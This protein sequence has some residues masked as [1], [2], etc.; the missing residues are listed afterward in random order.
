MTFPLMPHHDGSPLYVSDSSPDFGGVVQVRL[1]V[2]IDFGELEMV[3]VRSTADHEP[4]FVEAEQLG[5]T[6]GWQWWEAS[7]PVRNRRV[8]Y[9][10]MLCHAD[11]RTEWLS[12]A[13]VSELETRDSEDFALVVGNPQPSW[14]PGAV[15]YQIFPDRFARSAA[16]DD[17][18]VPP[19]AVPAAWDDPVEPVSPA[20]A[21]QFYGG[22]L[23]GI[24]EHL[25]HLVDLGVTLMYLTPVFPAA[26][27]HRY[28]ATTFDEVDPVL[29]GNDAYARLIEA[30]HDRGIR[31]IG[32]L[33]SNHSGSEHDWFRA[34]FGHPGAPEEEFYY[35]T[36]D[37]NTSYESWLGFESLPKLDWSSE[38]LARR[39]VDGPESV[40]ARWLEPP[41]SLDGW[42]IDVANMTGRSGAADHNAAVRQAIRRTMTAVDPDTYLVAES[43]ADATG[44]L[45]GDAWQG[46]MTYV[47]FTRP[48]WNWLGDL[49]TAPY[50][51]SEGE[52][53]TT[54][55]YFGQPV[56]Q[57][58]RYTAR[59]FVDSL[60][61]FTSG[62][63]W[64]VRLGMMNT[65][66]S[67]DTARFATHARPE[68]IPVAVGL[69]MTL[70]GVP[71]VWAGDEFGEEGVDGEMSRTPMPWH[72]V[73]EPARADRLAI[74]RRL[75]AL[76]HAHPV[77]STGGL[78]WVH[79][80]DETLLFV[81]ESDQET[82]LVLAARGD[83]SVQL[84]AGRV[85]GADE[86]V[87]V[88]GDAELSVQAAG[89]VVI[90]A[91]GPA[92]A[93]W[94]LPGVTRPGR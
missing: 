54:P 40:V 8:G 80:D 34:A 69:S 6:T 88:H 4:F 16:A 66:D 61:R 75:I 19:W 44:D 82:L 77:L 21:R 36:D 76:R 14:L 79:V 83:L 63:P 22:D 2:P 52:T 32:D 85:V 7:L 81:R 70:P 23:D 73:D 78:R 92:F 67:H 41:F 71:V 28:D 64:S 89:A 51:D 68:V 72:G 24:R 65:L 35:F 58:P 5:V 49:S 20:R 29:G 42:R 60:D 33:T 56:R 50:V 12:Q 30:A 87:A 46:A 91:T 37:A 27:N 62:I 25:D 9:R 18:P 11:G 84:P 45:Q 53:V 38:A 13:G 86:A 48:L 26:S 31:V 15:M 39:F 94:V 74:Y 1:R 55:W 90:Q 10:W 93:V 43:T 57:M 3:Q 47:P 17:R 59:Q